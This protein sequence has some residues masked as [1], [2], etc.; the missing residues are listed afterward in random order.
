MANARPPTPTGALKRRIR[1]QVVTELIPPPAMGPRFKAS[2]T[3]KPMYVICLGYF[4]GGVLSMVR[5]V[6]RA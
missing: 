4:L 1:L 2:M 3:T 6:A 5:M